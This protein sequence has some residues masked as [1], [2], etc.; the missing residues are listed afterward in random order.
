VPDQ[1]RRFPTA[2]V[3]S[4]HH[5]ASA[6]GLEV[7][8]SGGNAVDA[9]VAANLV[10]GVVAPYFCGPGGD[11]FAIVADRNGVRTAIASDGRAPAG[12]D[13]EQ[14]ARE[15]AADRMPTRGALTVT[16]PGAV[17][18]WFH[19]LERHGTLPFPAVAAPA[20]RLARAG[21]VLSEAG[22]GAFTRGAGAFAREQEWQR[23]FGHLRVG[24]RLV[25]ED[26][27]RMLDLLAQDGPAAFYG[28]PIGRDLVAAL[29]A[30]GSAMTL[31][32]LREHR[33]VEVEP[34]STRFADFTILELPPPTQGVTAATA[35]SIVERLGRPADPVELAHLQIEAVKLALGDRGTFLTDPDHMTV[36]PQDL[37][38]E[39]RVS[40]LTASIEPDRAG[41]WPPIVPAPGGTA[42]LCAADRDGIC[43]SLIQSN[44][45][46]F[47]SGVVL[48]TF[49]I[50]LQNRGAQFSL[51][52]QAANVIAPRK[53]TLHTLIPSL[54]L[55]DGRPWLVFGTMGGDGQP[56]THVQFYSRIAAGRD[57][58]EAITAPRWLVSPQDGTV[59]IESDVGPSV[60]AGLRSLGHTV[61]VLG[62]RES[63]MGHAHAI[64]YDPS[65]YA[66]ATDPRTEGAVVGR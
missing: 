65:G 31:E 21:F 14:I 4:P 43:I 61:E 37:L 64:R 39:E 25:Q 52:P 42:Y 28:G 58:Q 59:K 33:V 23:R 66:G 6:A 7:L 24:D 5:L 36:T 51:D 46:G 9:A 54:A 49:G 32:D 47:G 56:Q 16:V 35:L 44:F 17:A 63:V 62:P 30:G 60:T 40:R 55:R 12:A 1:S 26:H 50:N 11:L 10:L 34:L 41:P 57:L 20:V 18:G 38:A 29:A 8:A 48:P 2:A 3:A 22:A 19:L 27:A 53:R 13:P 15:A 45:M